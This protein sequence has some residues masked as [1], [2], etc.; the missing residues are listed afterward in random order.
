MK[1]EESAVIGPVAEVFALG[2]GSDERPGVGVGGSRGEADIGGAARCADDVRTGA[3]APGAAAR[4][5]VRGDRVRAEEQAPH[6][7][8]LGPRALRE[9]SPGEGA[10]VRR[11]PDGDADLV[12]YLDDLA[13][14]PGSDAELLALAP[15]AGRLSRRTH[16]GVHA[17][18]RELA[19]SIHVA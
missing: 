6:R 17:I 1:V 12:R 11:V 16:T 8:L 15:F 13:L 10:T 18:S 3:S 9:L 7:P 19:G 2:G 4:N 14:L 5:H